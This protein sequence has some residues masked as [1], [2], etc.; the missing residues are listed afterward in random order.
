MHETLDSL[1][2]GR[3]GPGL[4]PTHVP[5]AEGG[6]GLDSIEVVELVLLCEDRAGMA[7]SRAE[8]LLEAGPLTI[9]RL[10]DHLAAA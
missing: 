10:I 8:Q 1:W 5:L 2:P 6:L 7:V 4:P 3:F 9:A